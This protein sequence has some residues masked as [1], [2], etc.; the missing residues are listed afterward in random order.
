LTTAPVSS[1]PEVEKVSNVPMRD[2][3]GA[4]LD[5][6][7][8]VEVVEEGWDW[9]E[10]GGYHGVADRVPHPVVGRGVLVREGVAVVNTMKARAKA[11]RNFMLQTL[12]VRH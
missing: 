6:D 9:V 11:A 3:V 7:W 2:W 1:Q 10:D 8:D 4:T 12:K 5:E